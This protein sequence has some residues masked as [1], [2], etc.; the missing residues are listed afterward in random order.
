MRR[1]SR[2]PIER[3][4]RAT[5]PDMP[6]PRPPGSRRAGMC[7]PARVT[8]SCLALSLNCCC[9][10]NPHPMRR[11]AYGRNHAGLPPSTPSTRAASD[12]SGMMPAANAAV[13]SQTLRSPLGL[14]AEAAADQ[15]TCSG[16]QSAR[17]QRTGRKDHAAFLALEGPSHLADGRR[18]RSLCDPNLFRHRRWQDC[19]TGCRSSSDARSRPAGRL[20]ILL[21]IDRQ[22]L[23]GAPGSARDEIRT[24]LR[25]AKIGYADAQRQRQPCQV[26]IR[27]AG[28]IEA[29]GKA[30]EA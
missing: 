20:H 16:A 30:L 13:N 17:R 6:A 19:R 24:S 21:Q 22:D 7:M 28:Q 2:S 5:L 26:R 23:A 11:L 1:R 14:P 3:F 27:D 10:C 29:A 18:R 15:M 25:D 12:P 9:R 4:L 8:A